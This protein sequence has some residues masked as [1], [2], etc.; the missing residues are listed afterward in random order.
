MQ[1]RQLT[2]IFRYE[3][4]DH[5]EL[6][7]DVYT[8]NEFAKRL[9]KQAKSLH[10]NDQKKRDKYVGDGFELFCEILFHSFPY[11]TRLGIANYKP[12]VVD[13]PGIDGTGIGLNGRPA[14][15]QIK[16]R[17][18][19]THNLKGEDLGFYFS[20]ETFKKY[21]VSVDDKNNILVVTGGK[22]INNFLRQVTDGSVRCIGRDG[23]R[24]LVDNN[25][26]FW[27]DFRQVWN[28]QIEELRVAK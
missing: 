23:I 10:K 24:K 1:T 19:P 26:P 6:L 11:D 8:F 9:E 18:D 12:T 22:N 17:A 15:V 21:G 4:A 28:E 27:N 14:V 5:N 16:Y 20:W 13:A 25:V 7:A 2:H 3:C